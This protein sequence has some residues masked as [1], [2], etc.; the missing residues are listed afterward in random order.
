MDELEKNGIIPFVTLYHW[1]HPQNLER[2]GG[3][4]NEL[5]A[6]FFADYAAI[7]FK[8]FG[9]RVKIF[10]TINEPYIFCKLGY[11]TL[12]YAPGKQKSAL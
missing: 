6:E 10:S 3:W 9:P 4:T 11:R 7:V 12:D 2:L 1:D 5:M 8:E